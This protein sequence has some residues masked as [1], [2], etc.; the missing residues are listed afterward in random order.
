MPVLCRPTGTDVDALGVTL[1]EN[2]RNKAVLFYDTEQSE[3]QL[4]KNISN[5]LRRCGREAMPE[6][7]KAYCLT[8]MSRK[9]RLL[10]IIQS[11]DKYH[12]QYGGVH[13]V[14]IDGI[15]DLIK[16][17]NDEAESIA[18][19]EELYR[20]AGI[21]KTCIVT[22]LHFI[23]NGLK[24]RGHL[25][26]ELQRKAAAILSIEKDSDPAISVV[27]ALKVRD[28]SPLDVPIMQFRG[29][30]KRPC[31]SIWAKSRKRKRTSAKRMSL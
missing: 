12:Y 26:S 17:A 10:S 18:V 6:W 28:G 2:S 16:C 11:L 8:G 3:V 21:Y 29:I 4:Y 24:L 25:G 13:L 31:T 7:F 1:H 14:V 22:V 9:E 5:L 23:P 27:K 30:R 19:V 20:L 15:A